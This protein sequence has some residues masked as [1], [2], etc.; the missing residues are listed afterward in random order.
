MSRSR[1]C[2]GCAARK[3]KCDRRSPCRRCTALGVACTALRECVKPGPKG[4]W[5]ERKRQARLQRSPLPRATDISTAEISPTLQPIIRQGVS[6]P[7][8]R[9]YLDVYQRELYYLW[10]V[11][12]V[13]DLGSRLA[14]AGA[15]ALCTA[16]GAVTLSRV[17]HPSLISEELDPRAESDKLVTESEKARAQVLYQEN[18]STDILLT[19]FFLHVHCSNRGQ[20]C[21]ATLLLREAIT[22]AQL[23]GF[24]QPKHYANLPKS[25]A[26]LHLRIVWLLFITERGHTTRFDLPRTLRLDPDLPALEEDENPSGLLPFIGMCQ[27]FQTFGSAMDRDPGP[28]LMSDFFVGMDTRLRDTRGLLFSS[29]DSQRADFLITQQWMRIILWKLAM[30]HVELSVDPT[31]ENL[32]ISFPENVARNVMGYLDM[33]PRGIVE[34]HGL[35]M[36]M[37]LADIAISLADVLSCTPLV[38]ESRQLM[39]VRP[40]EVLNHLAAFLNSIPDK[41]NPHLELLQ[42]KIAQYGLCYPLNDLPRKDI[43]VHERVQEIRK[44]EEATE[45]N[46]WQVDKNKIDNALY[47]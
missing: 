42:E 25:E 28:D 2:D 3:T 40:A 6:T 21:K 5:A 27:L 23:L 7:K 30:F 43:S 10:P 34:G 12:D 41:V 14:D 8:R 29:P 13:E 39:R 33:F 15:Y 22:F 24:D 9:R 47:F 31:V 46:T 38:P 37:K 45:H 20:I 1:A 4:P 16:L 17:V 36:Q 19:S 11:I 44:L 18:P 32:S 26:Q 35:G